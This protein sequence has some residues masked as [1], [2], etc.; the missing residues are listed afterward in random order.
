MKDPNKL[1]QEMASNW[2]VSKLQMCTEV[3]LFHSI[4]LDWWTHFFNISQ[5]IQIKRDTYINTRLVGVFVILRLSFAKVE[6]ID[7]NSRLQW[8]KNHNEYL[9]LNRISNHS[10]LSQWLNHQTSY[11]V[12]I[13]TWYDIVISILS[14]KLLFFQ[15]FGKKYELY[16]H[17]HINCTCTHKEHIMRISSVCEYHWKQHL[18]Y[19]ILIFQNDS[20]WR[21]GF[22]IWILS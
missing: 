12:F 4:A 20:A 19:H 7:W 14:A 22:S 5:K 10:P 3:H 16:M 17:T 18:K 11:T 15:L 9:R 6:E 1:Y 13:Y 2:D 21:K 8:K